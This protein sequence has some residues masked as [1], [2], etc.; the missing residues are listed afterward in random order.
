VALTYDGATLA[1]YLDGALADSAPVSITLSGASEW[2][3]GGHSVFLDGWMDEV[4]VS[5]V[6]RSP[7]EIAAAWDAALSCPPGS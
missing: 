5:D 1:A 3:V 4:R 6:A 7:A 2:S